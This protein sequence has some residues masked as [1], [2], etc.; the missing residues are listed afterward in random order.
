MLK[1]T[2]GIFKGTILHCPRN[3]RPSS[4]R[5]KEYIFSQ[6]GQYTPGARVL[7]LFA[8]SGALGIEAISRRAGSAVFVDVSHNS[9]TVLRKNLAKLELTA[10]VMRADAVRFL[11]SRKIEPFDI[12]FLDPPYNEYEPSTIIKALEESQLLAEGGHVV[13]EM[14]AGSQEPEVNTLLPSSFRTLG[15]TVIGIWFKQG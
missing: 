7:D 9:L 12:I 8:G 6:I 4:G 3:I 2:G 5:V 15:D 10:K 13:F 1:V 14:V 11:S